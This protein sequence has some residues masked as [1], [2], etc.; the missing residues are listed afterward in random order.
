MDESLRKSAEVIRAVARRHG[1]S[2]LRVFGSR[3]RDQARPD[4]D[5]DLLV[6]LEPDRT[7]L[8]LIAFRQDL[9]DALGCRV[10]VVTESALSP[11]LRDEVLA[12]AR[13]L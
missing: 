10:D 9:E 8:D 5:L 11:Y 6:E 4:S 13:P 1:A 7:L 3:A 2:R 12:Q